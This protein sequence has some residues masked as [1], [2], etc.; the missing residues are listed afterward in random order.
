[1]IR[2]TIIISLL[3]T[4]LNLLSCEFIGNTFHYKKITIDFIEA[5]IIEDY[6][7][8]IDLFALDHELAEDINLDTLL[9]SLPSFRKLILNNFGA[10]LNYTLLSVTK[11]F[12]SLEAEE[13]NNKMSHVL[14]EIKNE[15]E[16]GI[17]KVVF[18]DTSKKI[19]NLDTL[20][21]RQKIPSLLTFWLFGLLAF[22]IPI[23]NIYVIYL[24]RKSHLKRKWLKY[25]AVM[26]LN[27][28]SISFT[29][30]YGFSYQLFIFQGLFGISGHVSGY[31]KMIWSFGIPIA[32]IYWLW[33][34]KSKKQEVQLNHIFDEDILVFFD[35]EE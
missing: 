1:M 28:P 10:E 16:F 14:I 18:D 12:S 7:T 24:I 22:G 33:K 3:I 34:L 27:V 20:N 4:I 32:G 8:C 13:A 23:F 19:L 25:L 31:T 9:S 29:P 15:K 17:I 21:I 2:K 5:L 35:E 11:Y 26:V 6:D 30:I